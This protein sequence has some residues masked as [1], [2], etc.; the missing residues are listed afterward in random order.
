MGSSLHVNR[1]RLVGEHATR[2][3]GVIPSRSRAVEVETAAAPSRTSMSADDARWI[4][5]LRT[6]EQLQGGAA[7]VL[8]PESRAKLIDLGRRLGLRAFDTSLIIAIA[9]DDAR[10]SRDADHAT[11]DF[12]SRLRM[13]P[14]PLDDAAAPS[15]RTWWLAWMG[16]AVALG[17]LLAAAGAAWLG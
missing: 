5:A 7:A 3:A 16:G 6:R 4:L 1:L 8:P 14:A 10:T 9:Q 13:V 11:A 17:L 15:G 12:M 2:A